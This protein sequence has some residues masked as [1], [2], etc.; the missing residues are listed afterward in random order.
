LNKQT[1]NVSHDACPKLTH[2]HLCMHVHTMKM[3]DM[4]WY[5]HPVL[6]VAL[7]CTLMLFYFHIHPVLLIS[8]W[9]GSL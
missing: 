1:Q 6:H 7:H 8:F 4:G 3:F 2:I 5:N 9:N